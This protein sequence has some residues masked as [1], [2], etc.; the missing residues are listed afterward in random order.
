MGRFAASRARLLRR[1]FVFVVVIIVGII[2]AIGIFVYHTSMR[3]GRM[4][5]YRSLHGEYAAAL[6]R[7]G[8]A[9]AQGHLAKALRDPTSQIHVGLTRPLEDYMAAGQTRIPLGS[10]VD[11]KGAFEDI[12]EQLV[13]DLPRGKAGVKRLWAEFYVVPGELTPLTPLKLGDRTLDRTHAEKQGRIHVACTAEISPAPL[14]SGVTRTLVGVHEFRVV[15][16]PVPLLSDF[17]LFVKEVSGVQGADES[18]PVNASETSLQGVFAGGPSPLVLTNG[19]R[20]VQSRVSTQLSVDYLKG[21]GWV[22]LGGANVVLN[23][24]Y[25]QDE[26]A[27]PAQIGEDFHFY[28]QNPSEPISGRAAADP[29]VKELANR[30]LATPFWEIRNWDMGVNVLRDGPLKDEYGEIFDQTPAGR[31][32][33]SLLKLFGAPPERVSPTVVFGSVLAGFF[34]IRAAV[35]DN[36][37]NTSFEAYY[38]VLKDRSRSAGFLSAFYSELVPFIGKLLYLFDPFRSGKFVFY[39]PGVLG[40]LLPLTDGVKE[41]DYKTLCSGFTTRNYNQA[42]LYLKTKNEVGNPM[43]KV[44]DLGLPASLFEDA[45]SPEQRSTLPPELLPGPLAGP[46]GGMD[47][48]KIDLGQ[49]VEPLKRSCCRLVPPGTDAV[50]YLTSE[51]ILSGATLDLGTTVHADGPMTL[52]GLTRVTRGGILMAREITLTGPIVAPSSGVLVLVAH[53]GAIRLPAGRRR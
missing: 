28:Q 40:G 16:A 44:S 51:G 38:T 37:A 27:N 4:S 9:L 19:A 5:A 13:S 47:L 10:T 50:T 31:R 2:L 22:F 42:L 25:S 24:S 14:I 35:P 21:Q 43:S 26:A 29:L 46:L 48:S 33:G 36:P 8:L 15:H 17:T 1:A 7:S 32:L 52:P 3:Q 20:E 11:L 6:A 45:A 39:N 18:S 49:L 34:R 41:P 53:S 12:V 23:L 30:H